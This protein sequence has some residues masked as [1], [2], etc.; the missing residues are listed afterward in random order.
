MTLFYFDILHVFD[1]IFGKVFDQVLAGVGPSFRLAVRL[2]FWPGSLPPCWPS[3]RPPRAESGWRISPWP[4]MALAG[5]GRPWR[6][7][8]S[9]GRPCSHGR[10]WPAMA[11]HGQLWP[12]MAAHGLTWPAMPGHGQPGP[13]PTN[14]G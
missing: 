4:A 1:H 10:L 5:D 8:A 9:Q 2:S 14:A 3:F 11:S 12:T 13:G 6:A 7:V